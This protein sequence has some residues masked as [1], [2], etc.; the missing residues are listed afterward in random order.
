MQKKFEIFGCILGWFAVIAQFILMLKNRETNIPETVLRF[1]SFFTI[2]TNILV[3]LFFTAK[4]F[5][6]YNLKIFYKKGSLIAITTFILVVGLVYQIILR[7]IWTP[8]G[9]QMIINELLH[10]VIPALVL[11]YFLT[12]SVKEKLK[13][14]DLRIWL[15]YPLFYLIFVFIRGKISHFF[16]YSFLD[17]I[18]IGIGKTIINCIAILL[19]ILVLM[20]ALIFINNK[21]LKF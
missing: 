8:K 16:P 7:S 17:F 3:A 10:S 21:K 19:L 20:L 4:S 13:F 1:F 5:N 18:Q 15:I 6:L 9:F 14:K 2:L 11:I 12:F